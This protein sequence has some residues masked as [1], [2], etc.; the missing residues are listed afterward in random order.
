MSLHIIL[1]TNCFSKISAFI[2]T[3]LAGGIGP[4]ACTDGELNSGADFG[5]RLNQ[6]QTEDTVTGQAEDSESELDTTT[7]ISD[8]ETEMPTDS[9]IVSDT[10]SEWSPRD[11]GPYYTLPK[12]LDSTVCWYISGINQSCTETC[13]YHGGLHPDTVRY[14]GSESEGGTVEGCSQILWWMYIRGS[15]PAEEILSIDGQGLGCYHIF[16]PNVH[17]WVK[18]VPFDPD[19]RA[20]DI[21]RVCGCMGV[22]SSF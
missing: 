22:S 15:A 5:S 4:T 11:C 20:I 18:D 19:A 10:E 17:Y 7:W 13:A 2:L 16:T 3:C 1:K 12:L 6:P 14:I 8:S 21:Q 9:D